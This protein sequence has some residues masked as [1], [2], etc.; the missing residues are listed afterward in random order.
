VEYR[1]SRFVDPDTPDAVQKM[2]PVQKHIPDFGPEGRMVTTSEFEV[3]EF[4]PGYELD[5]VTSQRI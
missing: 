2:L 3:G 5:A 1:L 4:A